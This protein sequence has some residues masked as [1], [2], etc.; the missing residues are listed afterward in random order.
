MI[1][2][3]IV[4]INLNNSNGLRRTLESIKKLRF[5]KFELLVIDGGSDD[6]SLDVAKE[7]SNLISFMVSEPDKGIYDAMNKGIINSSGNFIHLLNSGDVYI[8]EF[9]FLDVNFN[10]K[11]N[12]ICFPVRKNFPK[13]YIWY[14]KPI[15][16]ENFIDCAHPGLVVRRQ[17]YNNN[18]YLSKYHYISDAVFIYNN[19]S[20]DSSIIGNTIL[21]EM[22]PDGVSTKISFD[23]EI[24]KLKLLWIEGYRKRKRILIQ[25]K[26]VIVLLIRIFKF[27]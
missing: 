27:K 6:G 20:P 21:V 23:L 2:L 15:I 26:Y 22:E 1:D 16:D 14:P 4:T 8:D 7:Y 9:C 3:S 19:V 5:K 12:F 13:N 11:Q 25:L 10:C 18:L 17:V 24:E